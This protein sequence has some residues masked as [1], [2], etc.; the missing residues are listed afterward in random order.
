MVSTI[1]EVRWDDYSVALP[2]FLTMITIPLSFSIANGIAFGFIAYT[3]LNRK[4]S[5]LMYLLTALFVLR[6]VYLT[7][8]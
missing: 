1:A 2:A 5:W 3:L 7:A 4:V 8:G 6:F